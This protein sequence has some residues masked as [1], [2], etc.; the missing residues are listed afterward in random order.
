MLIG[1]ARVST[2]DQS[3]ALQQDALTA[4]GCEK[5]FTDTVSGATTDR[6]GLS[7]A[8]SHLRPGDTVVVWRLDRLGRSLRHLIDT[9]TALEARAIGFKS[10]T[11]SIDTTT[12]SGKLVFHIFSAL[13]EFER[14]VIRDRTR[15][16]LAAARAR[17]RRGGRPPALDD[18]QIALARRMH[19]DPAT[20][21]ADI[22]R[23]VGVSRAT[24]YRHLGA[25]LIAAP[26]APLDQ[27]SC[28]VRP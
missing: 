19:D 16:G 18:K 12:T 4:A 2:C 9:V 7:S 21:V 3:L 27:P 24:L 14:A 5:I 1:Y 25:R 15:A 13:A 10:L 28:L 6:D 17:G 26:S 20:T 8:L 22:C 23:A 11:E